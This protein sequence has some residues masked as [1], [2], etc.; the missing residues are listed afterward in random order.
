MMDSKTSE[1]ATLL[2]ARLNQL[3]DSP[4][5]APALVVLAVLLI[6]YYL[7]NVSVSCLK[8]QKEGRSRTQFHCVC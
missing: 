1:I 5:T 8:V 6:G 2:E 3:K 4:T 7:Y